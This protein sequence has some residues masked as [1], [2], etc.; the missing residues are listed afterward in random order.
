MPAACAAPS[1]RPA[2]MKV[3]RAEVWGEAISIIKDFPLFGTGL[4]TYAVVGPHYKSFERGG[5]YPHNSYLH[6]AAD[7]GLLGLGAFLWIIFTLFKT[8]L[9]NL[10]KIDDKFYNALL[11]GLLAGLFA[12][13]IH[14][15]VDTNIYTLQLGNLMWF[16]MGL[17]VAV[18]RIALKNN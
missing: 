18:Q 2:E 5:Y 1:P 14:S 6:M 15:F 12:F 13:L 8:S 10:K 17:I 4:N 11:A 3:R 7:S 9:T 16:I